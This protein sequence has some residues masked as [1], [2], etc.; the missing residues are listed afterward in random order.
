MDENWEK[1]EEA[2]EGPEHGVRWGRKAAGPGL[3]PLAFVP[4]GDIE[5]H[6]LP[7]FLRP[8]DTSGRQCRIFDVWTLSEDRRTGMLSKIALIKI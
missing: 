1:V 3:C 7:A 4:D 5:W 8:W 2:L 6:L